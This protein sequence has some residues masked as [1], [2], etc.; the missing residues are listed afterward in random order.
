MEKRI[1]GLPVHQTSLIMGITAGLIGVVF[2]VLMLP[3]MMLVPM[4]D[5]GGAPAAAVLLFV[6]LMYLVFGYLGT[7]LWVA[8]FNQIARRTG[9]LPVRF[10]AD[11]APAAGDWSSPL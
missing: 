4:Q 9:G 10:A 5:G 7:A 2:T 6:P 11:D 3:F 8:V 1:I